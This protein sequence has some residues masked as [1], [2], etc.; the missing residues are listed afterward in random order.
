MRSVSIKFL[1]LHK[2]ITKS[3][4]WKKK[5]DPK[6]A[7]FTLLA[8]FLDDRTLYILSKIAVS[9]YSIRIMLLEVSGEHVWMLFSQIFP[10]IGK[11]VFY[12]S[13]NKFTDFR[14]ENEPVNCNFI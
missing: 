3:Q 12:T 4:F 14:K 9:V 10:Q 2:L 8:R 13:E 11:V 6:T 1:W 5:F 7:H